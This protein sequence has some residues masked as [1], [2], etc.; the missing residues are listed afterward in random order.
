MKIQKVQNVWSD[1]QNLTLSY[2]DTP[3]CFLKK[4]EV[5]IDPVYCSKKYVYL[6]NSVSSFYWSINIV[7]FQVKFNKFN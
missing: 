5:P 2:R 1:S 4:L 6:K 3:C 7:L